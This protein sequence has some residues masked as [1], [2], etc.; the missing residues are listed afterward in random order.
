LPL[1]FSNE[2]AWKNSVLVKDTPWSNIHLSGKKIRALWAEFAKT[3]KI[4]N[5]SER[6]EILKV[7]KVSSNH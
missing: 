4:S 2:S 7:N 6:P 1:I 5:D 3:G